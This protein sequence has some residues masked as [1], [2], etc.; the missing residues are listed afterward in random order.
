MVPSLFGPTL[1]SRLPPREFMRASVEISSPVDFHCLSP[2]CQPHEPF[3][4][5]QVSHARSGAEARTCCSG[6]SWSSGTRERSLMMI[7]G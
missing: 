7:P 1:S 4:V 6:V 3:I 2:A 5:M